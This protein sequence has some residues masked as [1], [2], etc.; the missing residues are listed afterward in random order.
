MGPLTEILSA[1]LDGTN[2]AVFLGRLLLSKMSTTEV[3]AIFQ[4]YAEY[5]TNTRTISM[6]PAIKNLDN[7]RTENL[8][9]GNI[10]RSTREWATT[11]QDTSGSSLRCDAENGGPNRR[12]Q[13][14][15]PV[16]H[17]ELVQQF[18]KIYRECVSTFNQCEA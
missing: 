3:D 4:T 11:L 14:L 5:L 16:E 9:T 1:F 10:N 12:A 18:F 2:T 15:V 13:L 17:L 6:V 8:D 7:I